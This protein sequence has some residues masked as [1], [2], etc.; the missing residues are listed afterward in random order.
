MSTDSSS[1]PPNGDAGSKVDRRDFLR[2]TTAGAGL[3]A[4]GACTSDTEVVPGIL[5]HPRINLLGGVNSD[6]VVV[7]AGLW[8]SFTAYNLR[9]RG[10]KVTLVDQYGAGNSRAT[11]G[12]ETRGVRSTYG[13]RE[14]GELWMLWARE[15]MKRWTEF[16]NEW[17]KYWHERVFFE[18]GDFTFRANPEDAIIKRTCE[19]YD[20]NNVKYQMFKPDEIKKEYPVIQIAGIPDVPDITTV[21]FEKEAGVVRSR[22]AAQFATDAFQKMG[23][24]VVIGRCKSPQPV[25]GKLQEMSSKRGSN[26]ARSCSCS[27]LARGCVRSSRS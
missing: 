18:T 21:L 12:D 26:F 3:L 25:G 16:D 17:S 11:S 13:D 22:R 24:K 14:T 19:W 1:T 4:L 20:K 2:L 7:G 23:G 6:V 5:P 9:K 8:G 15:S 27:R 10:A